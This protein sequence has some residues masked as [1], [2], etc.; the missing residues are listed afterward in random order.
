MTEH[1]HAFAWLLFMA[2][3]V[4]LIVCLTTAALLRRKP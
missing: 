4:M 3:G 2:S 1:P